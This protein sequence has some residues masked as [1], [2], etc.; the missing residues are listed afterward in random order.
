MLTIA[1]ICTGG[2]G[3]D[4]GFAMAG[5]TP[6]WGIEIDQQIAAIGAKN[7]ERH[8]PQHQMIVAD[9]GNVDPYCLQRPDVL[10]CSPSCQTSSSSQLATV[11]DMRI[12]KG[13]ARLIQALKP[14]HFFLENVGRYR[15]LP[16]FKLIQ[17][18]LQALNYST[19][20]QLV[21][22]V[23]YG[24]PQHRRRLIFR[25]TLDRL[26][27]FPARSYCSGWRFAISDLIPTFEQVKPVAH[28]RPLLSALQPGSLIQRVGGRKGRVYV[29]APD[30]AV[31]T[32][33]SF[34]NGD[35]HWRQADLWDGENLR[36]LSPRAYARLQ[37][38]FDSYDLPPRPKDAI[39]VVGNAV[40]PSF[41]RQL[42]VSFYESLQ[43]LA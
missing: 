8:N 14:S 5:F 3:A 28:Q 20:C 42:G 23:D 31:W 37:G 39:C 36:T 41:A 4:I 16:P 35:R 43:D 6:I 9:V 29:A 26:L 11:A 38:F 25:A 13:T 18:T 2:G 22:F 17:Q 27:T 34:Q 32:I 30:E 40:P 19:D 12:A 7:L 33:R 1:S 21:D 15:H 24:L 10:W